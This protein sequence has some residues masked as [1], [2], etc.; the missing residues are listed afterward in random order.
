V[1]LQ[2]PD[3]HAVDEGRGRRILDLE[4]DAPGLR[5]D[6]QVEVPVFLEDHARIVE[7][8]AGIEHRERAF[9]KQRIKPPCPESRSWAISC[10]DRLLE[11]ALGRDPRIDH[12][13]G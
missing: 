3:H 1:I 9:A 11:A 4:L 2:P 12:V 10:C 7:I 5:H 13:R 8:A 6:P